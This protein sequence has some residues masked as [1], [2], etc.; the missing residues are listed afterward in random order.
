LFVNEKM[1]EKYPPQI[2][3][4]ARTLYAKANRAVEN[5]NNLPQEEKDRHNRKFDC[6]LLI[7]RQHSYETMQGQA[8]RLAELEHVRYFG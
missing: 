1:G 3:E 5:W 6:E 8:R 4:R 7:I 2:G